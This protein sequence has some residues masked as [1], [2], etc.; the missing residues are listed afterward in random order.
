MYEIWKTR[1]MK[2]LAKSAFSFSW[3]MG[4]WMSLYRTLV[5]CGIHTVTTH[6]KDIAVALPKPSGSTWGLAQALARATET[7]METATWLPGQ[8]QDPAAPGAQLLL[9]TWAPQA[10]WG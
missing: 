8:G 6:C 7:L 1:P 10:S 9:L 4:C 5:A 2:T 3:Q